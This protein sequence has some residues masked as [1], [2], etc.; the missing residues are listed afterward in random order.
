LQGG[1][2]GYD[3]RPRRATNI[4]A[5]IARTR[6]AEF[7][8]GGQLAVQDRIGARPAGCG[9]LAQSTRNATSMYG[10]HYAR[11]AIQG[12][13]TANQ[14][15]QAI[16]LVA[17]FEGGLQAISINEIVRDL[18][19]AGDLETALALPDRMHPPSLRRGCSPLAAASSS[20]P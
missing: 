6:P 1:T 18:V 5:G 12:L 7:G 4:E 14:K 9:A 19:N 17:S 10:V 3:N 8:A 20:P 15:Q 13:V 2:E 11:L 16:D